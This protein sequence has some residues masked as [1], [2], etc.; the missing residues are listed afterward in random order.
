M[1][2]AEQLQAYRQGFRE[3]VAENIQDTMG[4][5]TAALKESGILDGVASEGQQPPDFELPNA[6]GQPVRL[7][8]KLKAGPVVV[9]FYRGQWCP[10]CNLELKALQNALP[11]FEKRGAQLIAVSPQTPDN[12]LSTTEKN[13]LTFEVLSDVGNQVAQQYGLVF[14]LPEELRPIYASFGIDVPA[15]NGDDTFELPIPATYVIGKDGAIALAVADADYTQR[16]EPE[17]IIAALDK[18]S[19]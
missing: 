13:E 16:A 7:S 17:A 6:Q 3:K 15:H 12:S 19:N 2:L 18:L 8:E 10:Y 5:A 11:E 4:A 9:T 14:T 1:T